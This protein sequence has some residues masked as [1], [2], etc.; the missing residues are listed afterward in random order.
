MSPERR[1]GGPFF[2]WFW[3]F[4]FYLIPLQAFIEGGLKGIGAGETACSKREEKTEREKAESHYLDYSP[5][6]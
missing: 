3:I 6:S 5:P 2:V 1:D 4:S